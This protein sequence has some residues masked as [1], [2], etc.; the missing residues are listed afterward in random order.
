MGKIF[1][2]SS[3]N[4]FVEVLAERLLNDYKDNILDLSKVL[5]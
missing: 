2:V 5:I 3:S 4:C 1:N